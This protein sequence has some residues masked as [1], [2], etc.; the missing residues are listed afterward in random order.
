MTIQEQVLKHQPAL[1][2]Y[3]L[4][5]CNANQADAE[6][7][8]Q[9]ANLAI[10]RNLSGKESEEHTNLRAF[11]YTAVRN[12][13]INTYRR[14]NKKRDV[15]NSP[16]YDELAIVKAV[17]ATTP[18]SFLLEKE[19]LEAVEKVNPRRKEIISLLIKGWKY[20]EIAEKLNK[21]LGTVKSAVFLAR[22]ELNKFLQQ[23][24]KK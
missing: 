15:E 18:L 23:K 13:F 2:R 12:T 8:L 7:L 1:W 20:E 3:A 5:L 21:P 22:K 10:F 6:D 19:I 16:Q 4:S 11:C 9:E 24:T 14:K 17:D